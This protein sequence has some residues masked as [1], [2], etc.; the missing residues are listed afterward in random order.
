MSYN[1]KELL[2]DKFKRPIP[3]LWDEVKQEFVPFT[4]ATAGGGSSG[5]G[6][7]SSAPTYYAKEPFS[8]SANTIKTFTSAMNGFVISNDGAADLTFT[9]GTDTYTVKAG[10][11]FEDLFESFTEVTINSTVAFRAYGKKANVVVQSDTTAPDNVTNLATSSLT[12]TSLTLSWTASASTDVASY[13]VYS[14]TT[15]V[16]TV[17]TTSYNVTGLTQGTAYTFTIKAKDGAGNISTGVSVNATTIA[18]TTAPS[19]V[20]NLASSNI[21]SSSLTLSWTS[22]TS[23]DIASYEVYNGV[24]LLST[25][26]GNSYNVSGLSALTQY[27]FTVKAKDTS[28]NVSIGA[29][30]TATTTDVADTTAPADVTNLAASNVTE[31]TVDLSWTASISTDVVGY[32]V[33]NGVTLITT[34]TGTTYQVAGLTAGTAYTFNVIAKDGAGNESVGTSVNVTTQVAADTTP[35]NNVTNLTATPGETIVDLAWTVSTSGDVAGY[36][37]LQG[38]T[39]LGTVTGTTYQATGLTASTQYTFTVK[40]YDGANNYASGA[41]VTTTTSTATTPTG[42][43][44]TDGLQVYYDFTKYATTPTTVDDD[45]GNGNAGTLYGYSGTSESGIVNGELIGDGTG[46][47]ITIPH[48]STLKTYPFT[49]E[50]YAR[51]KNRATTPPSTSRIFDVRYGSG[52]GNGVNLYA[53]NESHA[54]PNVIGLDGSLGS[55]SFTTS[56]GVY[57]D[58]YR[59]ITVV[60]DSTV[61]KIYVDGVLLATNNQSSTTL[62]DR[63]LYLFAAGNTTGDSMPHGCKLFRFYNKALST[64]EIT[65]N[66]NDAIGV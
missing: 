5:G 30:V 64:T 29:S 28:G 56:L 23:S 39:V 41:S 42:N 26:T 48:K 36:Q 43:Y 35:P 11:V 20:T 7:S 18:D 4:P 59:H 10:E 55:P 49:I 33:Y 37:I 44:T 63:T 16:S 9:I 40:A 51:F 45:S 14:G 34:V 24:T 54:T 8:G 13:E 27:T 66:Y 21:S 17:T 57:D 1:L 52:T 2:L 19:E 12:E 38:T 58:V 31:T 15:L 46:D 3:Q 50:F 6:S 60:W 62:G 53:N 25:V 61:Q 65:Q 22:S 47:Y 32:D